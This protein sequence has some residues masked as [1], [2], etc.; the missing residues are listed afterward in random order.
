MGVPQVEGNVRKQELKGKRG[1]EGGKGGPGKA[2]NDYEI[3]GTF[4]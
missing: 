2:K 3:G 1:E 4:S